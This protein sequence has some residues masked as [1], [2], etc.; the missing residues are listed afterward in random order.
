M[1]EPGLRPGAL[2]RSLAGRDRGHCYVVLRLVDER[3]VVVCNGTDRPVD[4]PKVKNRKHLEVLGSAEESLSQRLMRGD[5]VADA[6]I[7]QALSAIPPRVI[8]E[9]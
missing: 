1:D 8:E 3:R 9:V 2:V 7:E 4:K 5:R 6:M